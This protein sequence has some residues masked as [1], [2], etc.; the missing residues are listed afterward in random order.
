MRCARCRHVTRA[1]PPSPLVRLTT[2][3]SFIER[4]ASTGSVQVRGAVVGRREPEYAGIGLTG[5]ARS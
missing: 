3:P 5:R 2:R 1:R 4:E